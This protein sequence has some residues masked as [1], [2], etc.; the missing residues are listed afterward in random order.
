[1]IEG[2][3]WGLFDVLLDIEYYKARVHIEQPLQ[4]RL[5][6]YGTFFITSISVERE[7]LLFVY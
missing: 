1:M 3:L 4:N 2:Y 7:P 6:I 5:K